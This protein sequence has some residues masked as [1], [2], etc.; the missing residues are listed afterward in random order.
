MTN[1][2]SLTTA[3]PFRDDIARRNMEN[4]MLKLEN[5]AA[6]GFIA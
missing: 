4:A 6:R 3:T 5:H 1:L 2:I